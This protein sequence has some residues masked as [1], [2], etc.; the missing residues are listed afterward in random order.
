MDKRLDR[1]LAKYAKIVRTKTGEQ[2]VILA[3][4]GTDEEV[5][6]RRGFLPVHRAPRDL[7]RRVVRAEYAEKDGGIEVTYVYET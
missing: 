6:R 4:P 3:K 1:L 5:C 2:V 7:R